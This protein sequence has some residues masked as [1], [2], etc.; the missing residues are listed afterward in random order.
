MKKNNPFT[1]AFGKKPLQYISRTVQTNEII[2][3]FQSEN[4]MSQVFM[5]TGV[6]GSGK[7][8]LMSSIANEFREDDDWIVVDLNPERKILESAVA[9]IYDNAKVKH[10][11]AETKINLSAF[12]VSATAEMGRPIADVESAFEMMLKEIKRKNK[13]VL[14]TLD[15]VENN[16][17]VREFVSA[18]QIFIR[19]DLPLY[20]IMTGLYDNIYNL[21]N[22]KTLT[23]LYRAPKIVLQP[24]N[25]TAISKS[26]RDTFGVSY[27]EASELARYTKG[28]PYAYQVLGFLL[29]EQGGKKV[30]EEILEQY[31][32]YLEEYVYEKL[33][34]E[35]SEKDILVISRINDDEV[36]KTADLLEQTGLKKNEYSVYRDRL[37]KKGII[38]ADKRGYVSLKLPRFAEFIRRNTM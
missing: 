25:H 18:F 24:L 17:Q 32:Q 38:D 34:T 12:G 2:D 5:I 27:D 37:R 22:E 10:L 21:Q 9:K 15:E 3:S 4:P 23:F 7:T 36:K 28:Y 30:N 8:V 19:Q 14:I 13:K 35:L 16:A 33:F 26:Y 29:W 6:R 31:D 1:L 11:F 20:L